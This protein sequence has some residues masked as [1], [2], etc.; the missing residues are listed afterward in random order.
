[1]DKNFDVYRNNNNIETAH[2]AKKYINKGA[3]DTIIIIIIIFRLEDNIYYNYAFLRN[4]LGH[5]YLTCSI[6]GSKIKHA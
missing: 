2:R 6:K 4:R 3:A 1:M 5:P